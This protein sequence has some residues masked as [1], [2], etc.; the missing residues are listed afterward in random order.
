MRFARRRKRLPQTADFTATSM[1]TIT[2][3]QFGRRGLNLSYGYNSGYFS[4]PRNIY[5]SP[6]QS[7]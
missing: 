6:L 3:H 4:Q 2:S 5:T 7:P 1:P